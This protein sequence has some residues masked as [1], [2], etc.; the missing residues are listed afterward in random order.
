[1]TYEQ[2]LKMSNVY[3]HSEGCTPETIDSFLATMATAIIGAGVTIEQAR[4]DLERMHNLTIAGESPPLVDHSTSHISWFN[5]STGMGIHR[6]VQWKVW[7]NFCGYLL[8][9]KSWPQKVVHTID[10]KTNEILSLLEDPGRTGPWAR[11]GMVLGS[12]QSGKTANYMGLIAKAI[13]SGYKVIVVLAG[14]HNSLRSQTQSRLNEEI[15]GYD[16]DIVQKVEGHIASTGVREMFHGHPIIQTLTS[17]NEQGDFRKNIADQ[18]G[19]IPSEDGPA[20]IMVVKKHVSILKNLREWATSVNSVET[21]DGRRVVQGVPLLVID[22]ECDYASVNTKKEVK[23]ENGKILDECDPAQTNKRIRELLAAFEKRAYVGYTAT[24]YAN[25]F[26]SHD[27][28]HTKYGKDLFPENF[29]VSLPRPSNYFG[30]ELVFGLN[31]NP[32]AGIDQKTPLPVLRRVSDSDAI[33]PP[34]HKKDWDVTELPDSLKEAI[35]LFLLACTTRFIRK[36]GTVHDSMLVHVTR[37]TLVQ[38]QVKELVEEE[39]RVNIARIQNKNDPLDDFKELWKDKITTA[40]EVMGEQFNCPKHTWDEIWQNL[41]EASRRVQVMAINGSS[42]DSLLYHQ[43]EQESKKRMSSGEDVPW[44]DR[45]VHVIAVGGDKLSRGLT[46]DGLTVSYYLRSSRMYDTLLQMGRWFGY[47]DRYADVCKIYTTSELISWYRHIAT[48]T[49]ELRNELEYMAEMGHEPKD[50]GIKVRSHPGQLAITSA[51]KLRNAEKLLLSYSGRLS[52]TVVFDLSMCQNNKAALANLIRVAEQAGSGVAPPEEYPNT[53]HWKGVPSSDVVRFLRDYKTHELAVHVVSTDRMADFIEEQE[54]TGKGDL[55]TWDI[56]I[57]SPKQPGHS[58]ELAGITLGC[59]KRGSVQGPMGTSLTLGAVHDP[60]YE[61][62]DFSADELKNARAEWESRLKANDK[63]LPEP[64]KRIPGQ[65][66]RDCRPKERGLLII[67]P[68]FNKDTSGNN[69]FGMKEDQRV[70]G[71]ALS[72]PSSDT[73]H[74]KE[75][76][77]NS[78]FKDAED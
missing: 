73:V 64:G 43:T 29:I 28:N 20:I 47:R 22:D 65:V 25:V 7:E 76:M 30:P 15:L 67:Y 18:A 72:F 75:F 6:D 46:L 10:K 66:L 23:D 60:Q 68:I 61:H 17:S 70:I 78:V 77:V 36:S 31:E 32:D 24:P 56:V 39:L 33:I 49:V 45:G 40:N 27:T 37:F 41:Y 14:V 2:I 59:S 54:R 19:M 71:L 74:H 42:R 69:T 26:I 21:E 53:H 52:Q 62:F 38:A 44:E 50:F 5:Q 8:A 4:D 34:K 48:A 13:D 51:G 1:M 57:A 35:K 63:A 11:Y 55:Q 9:A 12:V 3:F 58:F 16:L